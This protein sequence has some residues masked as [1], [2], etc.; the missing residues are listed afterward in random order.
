MKD[1]EIKATR[2]LPKNR[3]K[4]IFIN[5]QDRVRSQARQREQWQPQRYW[6][7]SPAPPGRPSAQ[8]IVDATQWRPS[9]GRDFFTSVCVPAGLCV[10]SPPTSGCDKET[11]RR[12][13]GAILRPASV[14]DK[15]NTNWKYLKNQFTKDE[16]SLDKDA[17]VSDKIKTNKDTST[18]G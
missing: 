7:P 10:A 1:Q 16:M 15:G 5:V 4:K 3:L 9:S 18:C 12:V 2:A 6:Q 8:L 13:T 14:V 11:D 17:D